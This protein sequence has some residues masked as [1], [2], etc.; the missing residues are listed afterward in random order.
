[1]IYRIFYFIQVFC[2]ESVFFVSRIFH[3]NQEILFIS[4][5][6]VGVDML[7]RKQEKYSHNCISDKILI[8]FICNF[9]FQIYQF[10]N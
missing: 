3:D 8:L 10:I 9:T 2:I 5:I 1:M 4:T 6:N 7:V